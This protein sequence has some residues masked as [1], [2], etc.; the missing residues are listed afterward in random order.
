M[1]VQLELTASTNISI[2]VYMGRSKI[3]RLFT[4]IHKCVLT[5]P[6]DQH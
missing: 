5:F 4:I 6:N 2:K 1:T 3:I